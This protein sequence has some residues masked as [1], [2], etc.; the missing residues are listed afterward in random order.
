MSAR[1]A[2]EHQLFLAFSAIRSRGVA[3]RN[4]TPPGSADVMCRYFVE[5]AKLRT[6]LCFFPRGQ[7]SLPQLSLPQMGV[8]ASQS[9][10]GVAQPADLA[11][12]MSAIHPFDLPHGS[13]ERIRVFIR[14][15]PSRRL[16]M[17]VPFL[18]LIHLRAAIAK[19][20]MKR[21]PSGH[22]C[23]PGLLCASS[24]NTWNLFGH[25]Q[26][27]GAPTSCTKVLDE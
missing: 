12:C 24:R 11:R 8:P 3:R 7:G 27:H 13:I 9:H 6:G 5:R 20:L 17:E 21:P 1:K 19:T 16:Y 2:L 18:P 15:P 23:G 26:D 22:C 10:P 4:L 25:P 14:K